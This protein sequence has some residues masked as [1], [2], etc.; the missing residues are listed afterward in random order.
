MLI[1]SEQALEN[2]LIAQLQGMKYEKVNI[3]DEAA[4]FENLKAQIEKHNGITLSVKEFERV[5]NFLDKGN[6]FDGRRFYETKCIS[7]ETT[8]QVVISNF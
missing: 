6:V 4:L 8:G 7:P 1:Q 2:C 3:S 5:L